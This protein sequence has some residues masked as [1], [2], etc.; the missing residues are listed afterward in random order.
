MSPKVRVDMKLII[1]QMSIT[2]QDRPNIKSNIYDNIIHISSK[3]QVCT[4]IN[5]ILQH[6]TLREK[7]PY[8]GFSGLYFPA[9]GLNTEILHR[10]SPDLVQKRE[11]RTRKSPNTDSQLARSAK[12]TILK[13]FPKNIFQIN[14]PAYFANV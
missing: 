2:C 11:I 6:F 1:L 7:C 3:T 10:K 5:H 4:I 13:L 9:F 14:S 8:S 12:I